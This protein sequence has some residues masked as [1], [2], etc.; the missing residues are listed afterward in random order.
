MLVS[1]IASTAD[2]AGRWQPFSTGEATA[3]AVTSHLRPED[4]T[5][6]TLALIGAATLAVYF[7]VR[8]EARDRGS[9]LSEPIGAGIVLS[10]V[11]AASHVA[12]DTAA[13]QPSRGAA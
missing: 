2:M 4:P 8:R 13:E 5:T 3:E 10:E 7:T 12:A 11:A 6:L 1:L 9:V